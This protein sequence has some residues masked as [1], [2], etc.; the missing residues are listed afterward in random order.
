[1]GQHVWQFRSVFSVH[2]N[3]EKGGPWVWSKAMLLI[4]TFRMK[5]S[6]LSHEF[7]IKCTKNYDVYL[8]CSV[9]GKETHLTNSNAMNKLNMCNF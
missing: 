3:S 8:I 5:L 2:T 7:K 1:M 9:D 6:I 4:K